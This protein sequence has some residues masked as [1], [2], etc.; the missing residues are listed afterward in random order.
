[1]DGEGFITKIRKY[2]NTK[3]ANMIQSLCFEFWTFG[4]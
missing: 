4:F 3:K 1:M 2:E